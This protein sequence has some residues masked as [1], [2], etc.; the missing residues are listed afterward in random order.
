M[1]EGQPGTGVGQD[2]PLFKKM[3]IS[4]NDPFRSGPYGAVQN[5]VVIGIS[6]DG[7]DALRGLDELGAR[8]HILQK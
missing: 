6:V 4:R 2:L 7:I 3:G 1:E 5:P 8:D